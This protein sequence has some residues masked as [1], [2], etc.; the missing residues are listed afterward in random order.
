MI[1]IRQSLKD[2]A[3]VLPRAAV[4]PA[5]SD[6]K[7][8]WTT[9]SQSIAHE[10]A[11][12]D[13]ALRRTHRQEFLHRARLSLKKEILQSGLF[14]ADYYLNTYSDVCDADVDP[15]DHYIAFGA[16]ECRNPN[17]LF[18]SDYYCR[19]HM[20]KVGIRANPLA[21]YIRQGEAEGL[22]PTRS[23]DPTVYMAMHPAVAKAGIS[24]LWHRLH[25]DE[26][27]ASALVQSTRREP[28][29]VIKPPLRQWVRSPV[30]PAGVNFVGP[31]EV[32]S[33]LG[34]S[35]RGYLAALQHAEMAVNVIAWRSGF[36][37]QGRIRTKFPQ[38]TQQPI[39]IVHLN[40]DNSHL[41]LPKLRDLLTPDRYNIAIWYWELASFRPDWM[42]VLAIFDEI[43]CASSFT[44]RSIAAI[45][46]RPVRV[47]R[48]AVPMQPPPGKMTRRDFGLDQER[49][50]FFF[51]CDVGSNIDRKNPL[52]LVRAYLDEFQPE[53]GAM[54]VLKLNYAVHNANAV[55]ALKNLAEGRRD[56]IVMDKLLPAEQLADLWTLIDCY[57]SP[58]RSEGLGLTVIEA[59]Y[60]GKPVI[61][62]PYGG[63][64]DFMT[65]DTALLLEYGVAEIEETTEPYP[66]GF[67]WADPK[68]ASIRSAMRSV[69]ENQGASRLLGEAGRRF[70]A[71]MF[72]V[73]E[74]AASVRREIDRIWSDNTPMFPTSGED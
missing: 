66:A 49:F 27:H 28:V 3:A 22:K 2:L 7:R 8:A 23:F 54:L 67:V 35:A 50:I 25:C 61:G 62:T 56:I 36:E 55:E 30:R 41:W 48:P 51:V 47:V 4:A 20:A 71:D 11:A 13:D 12:L 63:V 57:V 31:V 16:G 5:P 19:E 9:F 59:M 29:S 37:H 60:A 45:S 64:I 73:R 40:A 33:G 42:E 72:S 14:D 24:P 70:A 53:D 39:N 68:I 38:T 1:S 18:D 43:W 69:F 26:Q 17:R 74:T 10:L 32:I 6:A 58:H 34:T 21:H 65:A 15:L 46:A 52:A 44:A